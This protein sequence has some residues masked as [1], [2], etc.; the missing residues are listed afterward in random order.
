MNSRS[1]NMV[2]KGYFY[3]FDYSIVQILSA[4][5]KDTTVLIEG[6]EDIDISDG[7]DEQLIQCK[8]YEETE[9]NHSVIKF[10]VIQMLHHFHSSGCQLSQ[11]LQYQIYGHYKGGQEKLPETIDLPFLKKNFLTH[12]KETLHEVHTELG[13]NDNQL[14]KFLS[15]LK[16]NIQ[17]KSYNDQQEEI[18]RLL[19]SQ[20]RG[21]SLE[22]V[23]TFYYPNA[24]NK[25]RELA[26]QKNE[27]DRQITKYQFL[28]VINKKERV[29]QA[30]LIQKFGDD[31]YAKAIKKTHFTFQSTKIPKV[32]RIFVIDVTG[33]LEVAK[34]CGLLITISRK[35][36]HIEHTRTL[37]KDR[38]CPYILLRG[39]TPDELIEL[40]NQLQRY[41]TKF[42]DGHT[43]KGALFSPDILVAP[44]TKENLI[45]LKFIPSDQ[46]IDSVISLISGMMIEIFEF[47]KDAPIAEIK[48]ASG[49]PHNKFKV[50]TVHFISK[51]FI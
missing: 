2:I 30:W 50:E 46:E 9:Y 22:D 41:D 1:A 51:L 48:G 23:Q 15:L 33:E 29:F 11:E 38:F 19:M 36:S 26:I 35:F 37:D 4:K 40:K 31:A 27:E 10:A 16:I 12:K 45:K 7:A 13:I 6:S 5:N 17:A 25:I 3:Q 32:S 20:I 47:F 34:I 43:Y 44:P 39:V 28:E 8:Y 49:V 21:C 24:I 42:I 14:V 18:K